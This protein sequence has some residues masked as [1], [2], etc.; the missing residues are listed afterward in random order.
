MAIMLPGEVSYLLN[1]LGFEWPE[2]NEDTVF[3]YAK[4]WMSY[5]DEVGSSNELATSAETHVMENNYGPAMEAFSTQLNEA[6]GIKE[7]AQKLAQAG[8]ITGGCLLFVGGLI[9]ALKIA[10]V[11]NL[12]ILAYQIAAAISAAA[13]TFGASLAWIPVAKEICRRLIELAL[14]LILEQLMGGAA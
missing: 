2:G 10:F 6:E 5:G 7:V 12:C 11:V 9:I 13:A 1:M 3:D 8:N 14:N 4:R